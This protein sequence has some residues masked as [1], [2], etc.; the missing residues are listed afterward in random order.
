MPRASSSLTAALHDLGVGLRAH[1]DA[2]QRADPRHLRSSSRYS[3]LR[4]PLPTPRPAGR[5]RSGAARP[6][7]RSR[8]AL[9]G[10]RPGLGERVA[11]AGHRQHP[12]AGG[13]QLAVHRAR[14]RH[15][16]PPR[17]PRPATRSR[18]GDDVALRAR[19]RIAPRGHDHAHAAPSRHSAVAGSASP[20][21]AAH[22]SSSRSDSAAAAS[23]C[24]SGSPKRQL[25]SSTL[26]PSAVSITP[27]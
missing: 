23:A 12:A 2:H 26:G 6:R 4:P 11:Q 17:R 8:H 10:A 22:S 9:V 20:R 21:A 7:S 18:P 27:A 3:R 14:W 16:T 5:C 15:G 1:Q 24:V 13:D 19:G 25:N